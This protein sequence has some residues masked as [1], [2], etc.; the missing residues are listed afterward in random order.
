MHQK[1]TS[2]INLSCD[3]AKLL[4]VRR[5]TA[6]EMLKATSPFLANFLSTSFYDLKVTFGYI[7]ESSENFTSK[8]TQEV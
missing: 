7:G 8:Y 4:A 5:S 3:N 1:T 6:V 2:K